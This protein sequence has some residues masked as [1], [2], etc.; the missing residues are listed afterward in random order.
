VKKIYFMTVLLIL[1]IYNIYARG[2][3][4]ESYDYPYPIQYNINISKEEMF[5]KLKKIINIHDDGNLTYIPVRL[6]IFESNGKIQQ[7]TIQ[8]DQSGDIARYMDVTFYFH[9]QYIDNIMLLKGYNM[10]IAEDLNIIPNEIEVE[11]IFRY[12]IVNYLLDE[13]VPFEYFKNE[14]LE[15]NNPT[16][17]NTILFS[18]NVP[19]YDDFRTKERILY[20]KRNTEACNLLLEYKWIINRIKFPNDYIFYR[21][22]NYQIEIYDSTA[23]RYNSVIIPIWEDA[24]QYFVQLNTTK[25][26]Y[27]I[28][29][30]KLNEILLLINI[31]I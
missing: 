19:S 27:V 14:N 18:V 25:E 20:R 4:E 15:L 7:A 11:K 1:A 16:N 3:I 23:L 2:R 6:F 29:K 12:N 28:D 9:I 30:N 10:F 31:G 13:N 24:S 5:S 17:L 8:N 21:Y 22:P 26:Y